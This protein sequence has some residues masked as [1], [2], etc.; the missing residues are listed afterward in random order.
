MSLYRFFIHSE[1]GKI[2]L[3]ILIMCRDQAGWGGAKFPGVQ[4]KVDFAET[5]LNIF[6][7]RF[8]ILLL[9]K[10]KRIRNLYFFSNFLEHVNS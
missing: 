4:Q 5:F 6:Y 10:G 2:D 9:C 3:Y 1:Q 7:G 8:R